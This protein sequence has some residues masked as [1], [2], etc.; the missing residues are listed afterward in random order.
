VL[1]VPFFGAI[2]R[3]ATSETAFAL[4]QPGYAVDF[5]ANWS[6]PAEKANAVRWVKA[7]RDNL[8]PFARGAYVNQLGE[9]SDELVRAAYGSNYPRLVEIKKKYDPRNVLRVNQNIEPG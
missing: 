5:A 7:L 6:A 1:I 8:Q 4:R 2:T 3:V 9:T